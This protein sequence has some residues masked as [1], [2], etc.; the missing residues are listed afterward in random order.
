MFQIPYME[1]FFD[2]IRFRGN[3]AEKWGTYYD[4]KSGLI[5]WS[6]RLTRRK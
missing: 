1:N 3:Q 4:K 5:H 6:E 2:T